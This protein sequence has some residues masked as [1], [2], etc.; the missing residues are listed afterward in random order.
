[1]LIGISVGQ[2]CASESTF[3]P[4]AAQV[5]GYAES[6]R[7][8]AQFGDVIATTANADE[9]KAL[10]VQNKMPSYFF[11]STTGQDNC[12][13]TH[14][15]VDADY[16]F[17]DPSF[18]T[19]DAVDKIHQ[20]VCKYDG[21]E[22][23]NANVKSKVIFTLPVDVCSSLIDQVKYNALG[24]AKDEVKAFKESSGCSNARIEL[25]GVDVQ[26]VTGT[27]NDQQIG[28]TINILVRPRAFSSFLS[29]NE[30]IDEINRHLIKLEATVAKKLKS[31]S[32]QDVAGEHSQ[33]I[34]RECNNPNWV[35]GPNDYN[36]YA[37]DVHPLTE[38]SVYDVIP[39]Q[40]CT[41]AE[42]PLIVAESLF[43]CFLKCTI[44][45]SCKGY[46]Y[47][48]EQKWC[49]SVTGECTGETNNSNF[50]FYRKKSVPTSTGDAE[51]DEASVVE[52]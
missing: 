26:F 1:M 12:L 43:A 42:E 8:N 33:T 13:L 20:R 29:I 48:I 40:H 50:I 4:V 25:T 7:E 36:C 24:I 2:K 35:F 47:D 45:C 37:E 38:I 27:G 44:D 15:T 49:R 41:L 28:V 17:P 22:V 32:G 16:F 3:I 21:V 31:C 6:F 5:I 23:A 14:V 18:N 19:K 46:L 9:C 39:G 52:K 34:K 51:G 10:A 30:C 11:D